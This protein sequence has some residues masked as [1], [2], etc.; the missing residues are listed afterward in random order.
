[1][2]PA[3]SSNLQTAVRWVYDYEL[4]EPVF[5]DTDYVLIPDAEGLPKKQKNVYLRSP[6]D[7]V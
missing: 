2:H 6:S 1:M 4:E 7:E 3:S 5:E